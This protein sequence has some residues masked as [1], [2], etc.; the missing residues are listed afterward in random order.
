[1]SQ[2]NAFVEALLEYHNQCSDVLE[3]LHSTL[4]DRITAASS[5]APRQHKPKPIVRQSTS[6]Y[7]DSSD[8][9]TNP[10]PSYSASKP[11]AS[12]RSTSSPS[13]PC[14]RALY[15]FEAENDGELGFNEGD[16]INLV[17]RI[18]E[19][20]LEGEVHGKTGF[21]PDNYVEIVVPL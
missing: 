2:L 21:F 13:R 16:M 12:A 4:N 18:D 1:M 15:D 14:C 8:D 3:T 20:W 9:D 7:K 19:N 17:S 6:R 10:P 5:R 11:T